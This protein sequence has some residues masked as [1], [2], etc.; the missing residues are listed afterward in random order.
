M[1]PKFLM[2]LG[3]LLISACAFSSVEGKRPPLNLN[4]TAGSALLNVGEKCKVIP[5]TPT[6]CDGKT[7]CVVVEGTNE[8]TC[9]K[10]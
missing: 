10:L 5:G 4:P 9:R 1:S 7:K 2:L 6:T 8:G 3:L